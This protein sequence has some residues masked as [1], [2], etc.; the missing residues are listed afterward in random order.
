MTDPETYERVTGRP[1]VDGTTGMHKYDQEKPRVELLPFRVLEDVAE[2]LTYGADKYDDHNWRKG[3]A[4]TRLYGAALRHLFAWSE[5]ETVDPESGLPHL[6]HALCCVMFLQEY[7]HSKA[8]ED[9]RLIIEDTIIVARDAECADPYHGIDVGQDDPRHPRI[10]DQAIYSAGQDNPQG[11]NP[12]S[13]QTDK[14][15]AG[16]YGKGNTEVNPKAWRDVPTAVV[17]P[18]TAQEE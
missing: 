8:G 2:V 17:N 15:H 1:T 18:N 16:D 13:E 5:G 6:A 9:D 4:W 11:P 3:T 14:I 7:S 12:Y 10:S